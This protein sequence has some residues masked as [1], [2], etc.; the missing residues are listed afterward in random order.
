MQ[1]QRQVESV[2]LR[3]AH[4]KHGRPHYAVSLSQL[5]SSDTGNRGE[6]IRVYSGWCRFDNTD[7]LW[8]VIHN[9]DRRTHD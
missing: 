3:H 1:P 4:I 6:H 5:K 8:F 7:I 2:H 9:E